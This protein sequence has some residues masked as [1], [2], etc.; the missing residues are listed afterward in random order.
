MPR[1]LHLTA[2]DRAWLDAMDR[3]CRPQEAVP[4]P[5]GV[6]SMQQY[7]QARDAEDA[8][9]QLFHSLS[10]AYKRLEDECAASHRE[11][12]RLNVSM[13]RWR[14]AALVLAGM[15]ACLLIFILGVKV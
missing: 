3:A 1:E 6:V 8:A 12:K 9:T 5:E 7:L 10:R 15:A 14:Y 4:L 11:A 2:Q 13:R